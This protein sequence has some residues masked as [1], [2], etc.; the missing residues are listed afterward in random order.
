MS[1]MAPRKAAPAK[2]TKKKGAAPVAQVVQSGLAFDAVVDLVAATAGNSVDP[3]APLMD[4]GIDSLGAVEL[5]NKLQAAVGD[6]MNLPST[7]IFDHPTARLLAGEVEP[8]AITTVA[9][10][11]GE[12][13]EERV[14]RVNRAIAELDALLP[15][16]RFKEWTG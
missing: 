7:L 13:D 1:T 3:D 9:A 5:R 14:Q 8:P 16:N 6:D 2:A 11:A 10:A 4:N 12:D 15:H